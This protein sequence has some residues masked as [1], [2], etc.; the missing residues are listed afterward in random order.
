MVIFAVRKWFYALRE[1]N[2]LQQTRYTNVGL[3]YY[4]ISYETWNIVMG[5]VF[6]L[7]EL[8]LQQFSHLGVYRVSPTMYSLG[9]ACYFLTNWIGQREKEK[10]A[11]VSKQTEQNSCSGSCSL[12]FM[13]S[14]QEKLLN[15]ATELLCWQQ[16]SEKLSKK[17]KNPNPE[18]KCTYPTDKIPALSHPWSLK[19]CVFINTVIYL[20][21][22]FTG[23]E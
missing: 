14:L 16:W 20:M 17:K 8:F 9:V 1:Q 5:I 13:H 10:S 6:S 11:S 4:Q 21:E 2:S 3:T 12:L 15:L 7:D 23:K 18:I 22:L 19:L